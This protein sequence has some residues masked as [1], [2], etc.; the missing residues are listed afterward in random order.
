VF[1]FLF[2]ACFIPAVKGQ[3]TTVI[4]NSQNPTCAFQCNGSVTV[5]VTGATGDHYFE[6]QGPVGSTIAGDEFTGMC[7][8]DYML[9]VT[10]DAAIDADTIY[11][12]LTEPEYLY[13]ETMVSNNYCERVCMS[14]IFTSTSGGTGDYHYTWSPD[15]SSGEYAENLCAGDYTVTVTDDAGCE[16]SVYTPVVIHQDLFIS[17]TATNTNCS[18]A[19]DGIIEPTM[20]GGVFPYSVGYDEDALFSM[21]YGTLSNVCPGYYH[22]YGYDG[23]GCQVVDSIEIFEGTHNLANVTTT[24]TPVNESCPYAWDGSMSLTLGGSN[25]GPFTYLWS[26]GETT[27]NISGIMTGNYSVIVYD[28]AMNCLAVNDDIYDDGCG[29][30]KSKL[31]SINSTTF[32]NWEIYPNPSN[33]ILNINMNSG[34]ENGTLQIIN[35]IGQSVYE[36]TITDSKSIDLGRFNNGIYFVKISSNQQT[37]IKRFVLSK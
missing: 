16:R 7:G 4:T 2:F 30:R 22:I 9:V 23:N 31:S 36:E 1:S 37:D 5:S 25:T 17:L 8:G 32:D 34:M 29:A 15:V 11:F 33:G 21:Y 6:L 35:A 26:T 13:M 28:G 10:D 12:S 18:A 19:C 20:S 27:Q 14:Q 24:L 3:I